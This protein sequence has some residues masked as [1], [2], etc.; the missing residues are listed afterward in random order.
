MQRRRNGFHHLLSFARLSRQIST[1]GNNELRLLFRREFQSKIARCKFLRRERSLLIVSARFELAQNEFIEQR[2]FHLSIGEQLCAIS[3]SVR[4]HT[5]TER[6]CLRGGTLCV[7]E[8]RKPTAA[9]STCRR[10][11]QFSLRQR[12]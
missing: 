3:K 12:K 4:V 11:R 7:L 2:S 8:A 9:E 6:A 1:T 5:R 10:T